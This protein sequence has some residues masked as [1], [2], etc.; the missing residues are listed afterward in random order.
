LKL[1]SNPDETE[2]DFQIRIQHATRESRDGALEDLRA[3]YAT[4]LARAADKRRKAE[5]VLGREQQQVSQQKMQTAFSIGATMLGALMG[6]K[7]VSMSTLGRATTAARGVGRSIKETEDV[8]KAQQRLDE[9]KQEEAALEAEIQQ[10][11]GTVGGSSDVPI[12]TMEIKPKRGGVE[13]QIVALAW[14]PTAY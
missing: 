7:A 1:V 13:V 5:E 12:E 2:R 10:Q 9:A 14:K 11:L 6:R 4:R 8:G 3:K